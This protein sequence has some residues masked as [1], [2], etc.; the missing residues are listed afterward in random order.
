MH[1]QYDS[2]G[3]LLLRNPMDVVFTYRHWQH[4]GKVGIAPPEAF[5]GPKWEETI[6]YVAYAWADHAIRWIEQIKNG[7]VLFYERLMGV[8]AET[9]LVRL[10]NVLNFRNK[11]KLIID[12][13][14]RINGKSVNW[15]K[16]TSTS[17]YVQQED[18]FIGTLKV[19]EHL[20]FLVCFK[21]YL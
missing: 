7:T 5:E 11:G 1:Q 14:V 10:L 20:A 17:G 18:Y 12:G 13:D 6:D 4:G 16:I 8:T 2:R 21:L 3:V 9:E 15:K 19:K